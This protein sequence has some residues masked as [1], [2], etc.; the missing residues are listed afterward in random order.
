MLHLPYP[1][2][3]SAHAFIKAHRVSFLASVDFCHLLITFTN[4]LDI[5]EDRQN[6]GRD[7]DPNSLTL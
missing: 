2:L 3:F 7:L 4:S 6:A 5:D 1:T